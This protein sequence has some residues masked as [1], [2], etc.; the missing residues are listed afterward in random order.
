LSLFFLFGNY[1]TKEHNDEHPE[2]GN[3][4]HTPLDPI[5]QKVKAS[6]GK[7]FYVVSLM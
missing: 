5:L 6:A 4:Q 3:A 1:L 2:Q 7:F